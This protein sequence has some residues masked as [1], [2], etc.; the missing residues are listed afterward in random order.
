MT[1][2]SVI[3]NSQRVETY[4]IGNPV[5]VQLSDTP[6][7]AFGGQFGPN[8]HLARLFGSGLCYFQMA[9]REEDLDD[10]PYM[11]L[12]G[13]E[14]DVSVKPGSWIQATWDGQRY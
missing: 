2:I 7:E 14:I 9:D 6:W 13:I 11:F 12:M 1:A 3:E 8:T 4:G 5:N 10:A